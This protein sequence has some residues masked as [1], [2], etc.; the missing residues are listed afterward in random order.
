M[1]E[2]KKVYK[3][4]GGVEDLLFGQGSETQL[5]AGK[6]TPVAR[7]NSTHI[8]YSGSV[9][10]ADLVS[11]K[12]KIDALEAQNNDPYS[13]FTYRVHVNPENSPLR[14]VHTTGYA[15]VTLVPSDT[16][17][18]PALRVEY[19]AQ[20]GSDAN[21]IISATGAGSMTFPVNNSMQ[22]TIPK[23][24]SAVIYERRE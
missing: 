12:D 22:Y 21:L 18:Q 17:M 5:R 24:Y 10:T 6:S 14:I 8:P 23:L 15:I 11:V 19:K 16:L 2:V 3:T 4:L 9:G 13:D 1:A 20:D 7:I